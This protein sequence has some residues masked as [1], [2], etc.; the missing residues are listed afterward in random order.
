MTIVFTPLITV[1][2]GRRGKAGW[3]RMI[4]THGI[5]ARSTL[6]GTQ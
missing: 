6:E 2:A 5:I 1:D 4:G 3:L